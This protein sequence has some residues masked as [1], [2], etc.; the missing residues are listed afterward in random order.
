V[1][2]GLR[3]PESQGAGTEQDAVPQAG[4]MMFGSMLTGRRFCSSHPP[5]V[6]CSEVFD[7]PPNGLSRRLTARIA[8]HVLV[9]PL[10]VV[11]APPVVLGRL[12]DD[13]LGQDPVPAPDTHL[14][15]AEEGAGC[16]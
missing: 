10:H 13:H 8:G 14:P 9:Q 4:G 15:V 5:L 2:Q 7:R 11:D 12:G 6:T 16:N 1:N 3:S